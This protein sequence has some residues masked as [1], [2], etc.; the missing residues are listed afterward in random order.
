MSNQPDVPIGPTRS[1]RQTPSTGR[2]V[3][4]KEPGDPTEV[5]PA[6]HAED[7]APDL[8]SRS[9]LHITSRRHHSVSLCAVP[10]ADH[11]LAGRRCLIAPARR[12]RPDAPV[13]C[14]SASAS[15]DHA[16][17]RGA[18][19]RAVTRPRRRTAP[20]SPVNGHRALAHMRAGTLPSEG[21]TV[22]PVPRVAL[23]RAEAAASLG[24]GLDSFE[25]H[26]QPAL[27]MIRRG[28]LRL[29]PVSELERWANATA[30]GTLP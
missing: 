15:L 1:R 28:R 13:G 14:C 5:F 17:S 27:R 16:A 3:V 23:T 18:D 12:A 24:M 25:R 8:N 20:T 6:A 11:L 21:T 26:V 7:P 10:S 4:A 19:G 9:T 30:E 29:V 22:A 2:L